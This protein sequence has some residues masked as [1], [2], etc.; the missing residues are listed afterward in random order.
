MY[1]YVCQMDVF[2]LKKL[3]FNLAFEMWFSTHAKMTGGRHHS[4]N[5]NNIQKKI[6]QSH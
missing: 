2:S 5:H 4:D 1:I 6:Q 3:L